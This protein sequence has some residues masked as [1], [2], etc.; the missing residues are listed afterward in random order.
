MTRTSHLAVFFDFDGTISTYDTGVYL[1][2]RLGR[3]G[4]EGPDRRYETGEIGSQECLRL[5]WPHLPMNETLLR[6]TA[7]EVPLDPGF[8]PLVAA[9]QGSGAEVAVVSDGFGF[10]VEEACVRFGVPVV[11]N[12]VDFGTGTIDFPNADSDCPCARCGTCKRS[13][14]L[15]AQARGRATVMVGDGTSDREAARVADRV[16]ATGSLARWCREN[17]IVHEEFGT[18]GDVHAALFPGPG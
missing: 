9:L 2:E 4:W 5:Q 18:L 14:I 15:E 7:R 16:F 12:R 8:G 1:L 17:G 6:T 3:P 13:P 11:T 10:H